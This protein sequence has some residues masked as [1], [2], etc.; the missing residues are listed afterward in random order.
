MKRIYIDRTRQVLEST[1]AHNTNGDYVTEYKMF[2][3]ASAAPS[4]DTVMV[5]S[6]YSLFVSDKGDLAGA[7]SLTSSQ[8]AYRAINANMKSKL[9][10]R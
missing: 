6:G 2:R 1:A 10:R 5:C 3:G 8:D 7:Y 4:T 9:A